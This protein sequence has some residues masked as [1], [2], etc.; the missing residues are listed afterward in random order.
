MVNML[1]IWDDAVR[2]VTAS[3]VSLMPTAP[4]EDIVLIV[5]ADGTVVLST[6]GGHFNSPGSRDVRSSSTLIFSQACLERFELGQSLA[7]GSLQFLID[8]RA[9]V[10]EMFTE[11]SQWSYN[12]ALNSHTIKCQAPSGSEQNSF[13]QTLFLNATPLQKPRI[14]K[15]L[16][17]AA[18]GKLAMLP[19]LVKFPR[20]FTDDKVF[21]TFAPNTFKIIHENVLTSIVGSVKFD[22]YKGPS[23][24]RIRCPHERFKQWYS[25]IYNSVMSNHNHMARVQCELSVG[26]TNPFNDAFLSA[27]HTFVLTDEKFIQRLDVLYALDDY[28]VETE[29]SHIQ[30]Q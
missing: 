18:S 5:Q 23:K 13:H 17:S 12:P 4:G 19:K 15:Q 29:D 27:D 6:D 25:A 22:D 11:F 21:I 2:R 26:K 20:P 28:L 7:D 9:F 10:A 14:P 8:R 24:V 3:L 1:L 30:Q 16:V